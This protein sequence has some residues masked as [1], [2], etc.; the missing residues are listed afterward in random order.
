V[1]RGHT[2]KQ[3]KSLYSGTV[4]QMKNITLQQPPKY[5]KQCHII[6]VSKRL[7]ASVLACKS[8]DDIYQI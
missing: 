8:L 1:D 4:A 6:V 3:K 5:Y 2:A 7:G